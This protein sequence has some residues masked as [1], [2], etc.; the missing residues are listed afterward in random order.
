MGT[1]PESGSSKPEGFEARMETA[2]RLKKVA[3]RAFEH[4]SPDAE[5]LTDHDA[6]F[7][8]GSGI[9]YRRLKV[10]D[11]FR[12]ISKYDYDMETVWLTDGERFQIGIVRFAPN[13]TSDYRIEVA[14][15]GTS[16][17]SEA[18][19]EEASAEPYEKFR[20]DYHRDGNVVITNYGGPE[21]DEKGWPTRYGDGTTGIEWIG[22]N[23]MGHAVSDSR[24][25]NLSYDIHRL[26]EH[27]EE[28]TK[29]SG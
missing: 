20:V 6:N 8:D 13:K 26:S 2:L 21:K 7:T 28:L 11:E 1:P 19:K 14:R 4:L 16:D 25:E 24:L 27:P 3:A 9:F 29:G 23:A 15:Y 10:L 5:K 17:A 12:S 22:T 18:G